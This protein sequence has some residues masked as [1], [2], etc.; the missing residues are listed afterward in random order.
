MIEDYKGPY[1]YNKE[2]VSNW[3]STAIGVYYCGFISSNNVLSVLYVGKGTSDKG[4]R[5]RL[6]QHLDEDKWPDV[7][8]FGYCICSTSTEA[9]LF[10]ASE[11]KRLKPK[12]NIQGKEGY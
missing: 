3:E 11:I 9:E 7:S 5:G 12:Y 8:H 6:L 2:I 1:L 4:I 10:E